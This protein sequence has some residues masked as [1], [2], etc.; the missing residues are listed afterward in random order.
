[1]IPKRFH[2]CRNHFDVIQNDSDTGRIFSQP[3]LISFKRDKNTLEQTFIFQIGT[4]NP[5]GINEL[6]SFN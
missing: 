5:N 1:M 3:P 2:Q 6:F 4:L